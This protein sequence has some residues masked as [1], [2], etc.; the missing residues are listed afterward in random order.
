M[1][2]VEAVNLQ[3]FP[4]AQKYLEANKDVLNK[5]KYVIDAGKKWYEIWNT[6]DLDWFEQD[7]IITPNLS[8]KNNFS[9]DFK[10]NKSGKY[11]YIDHDCYGIILKNKSRQNYLYLLGLLN[12]K[13][14]EFFIKQKSP[15]FSGGY[16]KYHTQYLEQIPIVQAKEEIKTNVISLV[17]RLI[18]LNKKLTE[19]GDKKTDDKTKIENEIE[20]TDTEIDKIIYDIYGMTK[21]ERVII[22]KA[23]E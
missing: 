3:I 17:N 7:K 23:V 11:F 2:K 20:R 19:I 18:S 8:A 5:R 22:E 21:D 4:N 12:S 16:Y 9:I 14:I 10:D 6:R 13:L 1:S 15:M